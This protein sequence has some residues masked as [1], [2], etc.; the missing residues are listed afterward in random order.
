MNLAEQYPAKIHVFVAAWTPG[1]SDGKNQPLR[2]TPDTNQ[3]GSWVQAQGC[4]LEYNQGGL[5]AKADNALVES[6][7]KQLVAST[8]VLL[9]IQ[10]ALARLARCLGASPAPPI[11]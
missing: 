3:V 6:I 1:L 11:P 7:R 4:F 10:L 5:L 2:H 9:Q 8:A